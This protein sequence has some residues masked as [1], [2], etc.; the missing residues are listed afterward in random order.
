MGA[1]R[2]GTPLGGG[3][4]PLKRTFSLEALHGVKDDLV[5]LKS[6]WFNKAKGGDHAQ[7]LDN[8]YSPQAAA[9]RSTRLPDAGARAI[10]AASLRD[11]RSGAGTASGLTR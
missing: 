11:Q 2:D 9:C 6:I 3:R 5:V 8:F 4:A 1:G 10:P 7:R